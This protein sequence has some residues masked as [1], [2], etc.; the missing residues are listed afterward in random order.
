MSMPEKW[1]I[2]CTKCR[3]RFEAKVWASINTNS[4]EL[5]E[6]F[7]RG[8][9]NVVTCPRCGSST[10]VPNPVLY[11]DLH[12]GLWVKVDEFLEPAASSGKSDAGIEGVRY[13]RHPYRN[14]QYIT[15][16]SFEL[17]TFRCK[18]DVSDQR[19]TKRRTGGGV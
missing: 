4:P 19:G 3:L 1:A 14:I 15:V 11:N 6:A 18:N 9:L 8:A 16:D 12:R 7:L 2:D 13:R 10:F 5:V 17:A